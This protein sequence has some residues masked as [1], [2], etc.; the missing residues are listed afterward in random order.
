[1]CSSLGGAVS[2][3]TR[4]NWTTR[5]DRPALLLLHYSM[6]RHDGDAS[7]SAGSNA[8]E[9]PEHRTKQETTTTTTITTTRLAD[10]LVSRI[11]AQQ[12][13]DRAA[14]A[15]VNCN[16]T[17]VLSSTL[18]ETGPSLLLLSSV[19]IRRNSGKCLPDH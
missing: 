6:S 4:R 12:I 14:P 8:S 18:V 13:L 17:T 7:D 16:E 15:C 9:H 1:M 11:M 5:H 2:R 3:L 19:T 10:Q